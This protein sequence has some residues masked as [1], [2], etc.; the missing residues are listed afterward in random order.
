MV[1]SDSG[2]PNVKK[3]TCALNKL[4]ISCLNWPTK[5]A[6]L[7]LIIRNNQSNW[8]QIFWNNC[9]T[10]DNFN[11]SNWFK[12]S[13]QWFVQM[14]TMAF[15]DRSMYTKMNHCMLFKKKIK[16][17]CDLTLD[18]I[19]RPETCNRNRGL[20]IRFECVCEDVYSRWYWYV[21]LNYQKNCTHGYFRP[22]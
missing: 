15:I 11:K 17:L 3:I 5:C 12:T 2:I 13:K 8:M 21:P 22:V 9:K 20:N 7:R 4:L 16:Y 19:V 6:K 10:V 1:I 14:D 18:H